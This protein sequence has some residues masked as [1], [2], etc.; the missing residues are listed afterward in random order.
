MFAA[1]AAT[2]PHGWRWSMRLV[3]PR[4]HERCY[5]R[6]RL[7]GVGIE[8][9]LKLVL[10]GRSRHHPIPHAGLLIAYRLLEV[11]DARIQ[12]IKESKLNEVGVQFRWPRKTLGRVGKIHLTKEKA[13]HFRPRL[14]CRGRRVNRSAIGR[15]GDHTVGNDQQLPVSS[16]HE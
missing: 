12:L 3:V 6:W 8:R 16:R 2:A 9:I 4:R 10:N 15:S 11:R 13:R 1:F 5:A 7:V 14:Y